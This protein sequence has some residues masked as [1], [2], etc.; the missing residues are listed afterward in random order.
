MDA[1]DFDF[2]RDFKYTQWGATLQVALVRSVAVGI[3]CAIFGL[4]MVLGSE[5]SVSK[6]PYYTFLLM[7]IVMPLINLFYIPIGLVCGFLSSKGVPWVGLVTGLIALFFFVI[8]DP[9]TFFIHKYKKSLVPVEKFNFL[10]FA[11]IIWVL[12]LERRKAELGI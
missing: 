3:V 7:P 9:L 2:K 12:D 4:I 10:N 6:P 5:P 11:I 1:I 8:G